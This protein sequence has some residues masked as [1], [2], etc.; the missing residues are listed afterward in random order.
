MQQG[1]DLTKSLKALWR[2][3]WIIALLV[4]VAAGTA[5]KFNSA[6]PT[7]YKATATVMVQSGQSG[8]AS[9]PVGLESVLPFA[10]RQDIG[11]QL[12]VMQSRSVLERAVT[13][14]E[15]E[16]VE[17]PEYLQ[18]EAGKLA[19]SLKVQQVG[20]ASLVGVTV[21]SSDPAKAQQQA[22]AVAEAYIYEVSKAKL[23]E[24]ETALENTT[25]QM[26]ELSA[27][28]VDL[29]LSPLLTPIIAK[30]DTALAA[31]G[32]ATEHLEEVEAVESPG[33]AVPVTRDAGTALTPLQLD[34][35]SQHVE[36]ISGEAIDL[37]TLT[38]QL[39]SES[40]GSAY[41]VLSSDT[42]DIEIRTRALATKLA[43]LIAEV[44]AVRGVEIDPQVQNQLL[45]IEEQLRVASAATGAVLNQVLELYGVRQRLEEAYAAE[46]TSN[47]E[48]TLY[49][50]VGADLLFRMVEHTN[51]TSTALEAVPGHLEQ[52][53]PREVTSAQWGLQSLIET[54][55][56]RIN[57]GPASVTAA[58]ESILRELQPPAPEQS[59]LLTHGELAAIQ[60]NTKTV[61]VTLAFLLS[62]VEQMQLDEL[63]SNVYTELL[64]VKEQLRIAN[65]A[66]QGLPAQIANLESGGGDSLSSAS[67]NNLRQQLQLQL[68]TSSSGGARIVD[69]AVVSS[70]ATTFFGR[71]RSVILAAVAALLLGILS[72]LL[73]QYF[74][75]K[76]R[77]A[78]QV[79]SYVGIPVLARIA[80]IEGAGNPHPPSFKESPSQYLEAFRMLRTNLGLDSNRGLVLLVSGPGEEEGKTTIAANL[81]RA[82][83]LQ[84]R[85]VLLID[86]N[87]RKPGIAEAFELKQADGLSDFL[88]GKNEPQD[89]VIQA[90]GID[91]LPVRG[92]SVK[93]A[94]ELSSPRMKALLEKA[95]QVY[96]VVIVDS[97]P[98]I[99]YADTRIL[100]KWV[101]A[102]LLVLQ[103]D[104]SR[105][106]LTRDSKQELESM[107]VQVAGFVLNKEKSQEFEWLPRIFRDLRKKKSQV[108]TDLKGDNSVAT[109]H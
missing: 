25:N 23:A 19:G 44:G 108:Q 31:L 93:S 29:S 106:D 78:S 86:G 87:L 12:Q 53:Q 27:T 104:V 41:M 13:Q 6:Q 46:F 65:D 70:Q 48:V 16:K 105:L 68:L 43:S 20:N 14:L 69:E 33:E 47:I 95:R 54:L 37:S 75:R 97:A 67:L 91:I 42:A 82:V 1:F 21:T 59:V 58:L 56:E 52:I 99:E 81:A 22:N 45:A 15:P 10:Y 88:K 98:V 11:S 38:Q 50:A 96:D 2:F 8:L 7:V 92:A 3:K 32:E 24:I 74:D 57:G 76:V 28:K 90:D 60:N 77:D 4:L 39:K 83:A 72:V 26:K 36:V 89:Y 18:L 35:L 103:A 62:Q 66:V 9:L 71:L 109:K 101:D 51:L 107:G 94:E 100:A 64:Y 85:K 84:G 34:A 61:S 30:T 79:A 80:R 102:V 5:W 63:D 55:K 40:T 73:F 49:K 17:N